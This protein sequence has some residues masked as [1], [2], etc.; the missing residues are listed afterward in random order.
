MKYQRSEA[1]LR[2]IKQ[3][4][5]SL[6]VAGI[7]AVLVVSALLSFN[8]LREQKQNEARQAFGSALSESQSQDAAM[9]SLRAVA[10]DYKGSVYATYSLMLL[11]QNLLGRGEYREAVV[12]FADALKSKQPA[13]FVTAQIW[14][15]KA[16]ALEFDGSL[17]E[18]LTAYQRALRVPNNLYRK[19]EILLKSALLNLRMGQVEQAKRQF[20]EIVAD[21]AANE[22]VLRI[23]RNEIAALNALGN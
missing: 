18:A 11:G 6:I 23:A 4:K 14:E 13:A 17:D 20:E 1:A 19:N 3:K 22:R 8:Y 15:S 16:T 21:S 12:V 2:F 9:E 5:D 10:Q 7:V